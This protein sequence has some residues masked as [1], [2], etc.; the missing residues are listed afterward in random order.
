MAASFPSSRTWQMLHHHRASRHARCGLQSKEHS[1]T[2]RGPA[3]PCSLSSF[4]I[5]PAMPL[6]TINHHCHPHRVHY[7][8]HYHYHPHQ[9]H[10]PKGT[11]WSLPC[12]LSLAWASALF[13]MMNPPLCI[14]ALLS[15]PGRLA[16]SGRRPPWL[17]RHRRLARLRIFRVAGHLVGPR[18][19]SK[20]F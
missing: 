9:K 18:I 4:C 16:P 14:V 12:S 3:T 17:P 1:C 6:W 2:R 15:L 5:Q 10:Q 19:Y 8:Y 13:Q 11:P 20:L 7:H